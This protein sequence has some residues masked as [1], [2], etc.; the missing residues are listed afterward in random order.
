[1]GKGEV[2]DGRLGRTL[3]N[4]ILPT[5]AILLCCI[6]LIERIVGI[7]RKRSSGDLLLQCIPLLFLFG[8]VCTIA[9]AESCIRHG[10]V[11]LLI[12]PLYAFPRAQAQDKDGC[13]K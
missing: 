2:P 9:V 3:F 12:C 1:M 11:A 4:D 7:M 8:I 6:G 10:I 5:L 13:M